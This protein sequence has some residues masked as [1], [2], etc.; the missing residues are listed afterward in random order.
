MRM[1]ATGRSGAN[2]GP[3]AH[4]ARPGGGA[5][6]RRR[7]VRLRHGGRRRPRRDHAGPRADFK[8]WLA[9]GFYEIK[10]KPAVPPR[11]P[12]RWASSSAGA[13]STARPAVPSGLR[14]TAARSTSTWPT[15][16]GGRRDRRRAAGAS[17]RSRRSGSGGR[18]GMLPLPSPARGGWLDELRAYQRPPTTPL[19]TARR[20]DGRR[21]A[22]GAPTRRC[23]CPGEQGAPRHARPVRRA[24]RPHMA[25]LRASPATARDLIIAAHNVWVLALTT[26]YR[27]A[28]WL[29]DALCR[30]AT[31]GGFATRQLYTDDEETLF[32]APAGGVERHRGRGRAGGPAGPRPCWSSCR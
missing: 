12:M 15:T 26:C 7:A 3:D 6:P 31:G 32:D 25:P 11:W 23:S 13:S 5:V 8:H 30:L 4:P 16:A 17:S 2:P 18:E 21:A 27:A 29:S 28:T 20:L 1:T 9:K 19:V 22:A 10:G 14:A 24:D